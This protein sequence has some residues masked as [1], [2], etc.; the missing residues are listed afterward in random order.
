[1]AGGHFITRLAR[2]YGVLTAEVV[3]G[4][5]PTL[6]TRASIRYFENMGIIQ[7]PRRGTFRARV[8]PPVQ[9]PPPPSVQPPPQLADMHAVVMDLRG[10]IEF[11]EEQQAWIGDALL[12]LLTQSG[13]QPR[14]FPAGAHDDEEVFACE[15]QWKSTEELFN[16]SVGSL[17]PYTCHF[18]SVFTVAAQL[19]ESE[20]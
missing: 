1:M 9:R 2:S 7:Q 6:P 14:P 15:Y 18:T 12:T 20:S 17:Y 16:A 3:V 10:R 4:L 19:L 13:H 8:D 11:L 5:A